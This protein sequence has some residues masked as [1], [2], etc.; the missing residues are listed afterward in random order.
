M[1]VLHGTWIPDR[2]DDFIQRGSFYLWVETSE[3]KKHSAKNR[4]PRHLQGQPLN[5]FIRNELGIS[6]GSYLQNDV[7]ERYF[8]LPSTP[9]SP[10][11]SPELA[12]YL[13]TDITDRIQLHPWS[14]DCVAIE[15]IIKIVND[16]HFLAFYNVRDVQ[17][18]SDLLFWYHYTQFFRQ[19]FLKDQ[20]IPALKYRE[21]ASK[22]SKNKKTKQAKK[23]T[24]FKIY[25]G[26]EVVA[27]QYESRL[28]EFVEMMPTACTCGLETLE[29][30]LALWEKETLLRHFSEC[31]LNDTLMQTTLPMVFT[32]KIEDSLI[33]DCLYLN[34]TK[35]PP[36]ESH[37]LTLETYR[38]WQG[39]RQQVVGDRTH[40]NFDLGFKLIEASNPDTDSWKVEFLA[41]AQDDPSLKLSLDD[42]WYLEAKK[43]TQI[44]QHFG[45]EFEKNILLELGYAARMYPKIWSGLETDK[46]IGLKLTLTE[47]FEFLKESAWVLEDSG[48]K[49]IIPAWWTPEGRRRAKIRLKVSGQSSSSSS[50]QNKGYFSL[51]RIVRYQY[52]L[53]L[54]GEAVSRREWEQ[55]IEA[56]T[57]LVKFRGQWIEIDRQKM[58]EM[59]EFWRSN[60]EGNPEM[61][62]VDLLK[63][64]G[65]SADEIEVEYDDTLGKMMLGLRDRSQLEPIEDPPQLHATLREYQKRGVSWMQYLERL[66]LNG[67]LA[68][69]MGLGKTMQTIARLVL[70]REGEEMPPPTLLVAPTSVL[71]NWRKEV[72]KFAP[73]LRVTIHHGSNRLKDIEA[74]IAAC[75]DCD[76][77]ITS[78]TLARQDAKL[79]GG[80]TWQ[81]IVLDEAQNIKNP[82]AAQTKAILKL[83]SK[84]RLALTGTPVENRLL[85][86]WSIFNFLNPGYLGKQAQFR[87]A[88]ELPIQKEND[89]TKSAILKKLVEPF[90][91][92]RVKTDK[93]I[94]RDLPDKVE[95]KQYCN[96]TKEQAS[97]Y[98]AVI[99]DV[100]EQLE[101]A[102]GIQRKGLI[103]A[104]LTKLKQICNHPAQFL[105]DGSEF[106]PERSHKFSRLQEMLEEVMAEGDSVLIFS[107]FRTI[108][109]ALENWLKR[110]YNTYY[111]HGGTSRQKREKAIAQFQD[112]Q[113]EP[114]I[115]LLSLKAG[116]VGITLTKANHVFHFDRWWNPAVEDQATDRAFRIG[117]D[118]NVFVH[119]F[120]AI[121]TLEERIDRTLEDKKQIAS[122]IVGADESWL[123]ELDNDSFKQLISLDRQAVL[124]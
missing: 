46:P 110:E 32:R 10:L 97:L 57:P 44:R 17:L 39:W 2:S 4:H 112:P 123:T 22:T 66:G 38:Q 105:Q 27:T 111:I 30:S 43:K 47:A 78:F 102:D 53:S 75:G 104:T 63:K 86:L 93:Q 49:V 119:K 96:L 62:I 50:S 24:E 103:L 95:H 52:E 115:F 101:S 1:K 34:T 48:Y 35:L 116:G 88:F 81:R 70:E 72:E 79:L 18:G 120:I 121:G 77:V 59:L 3:R 5:D 100:E 21:L 73:H 51:D 56:K 41:I 90:I 106:S 60:G 40:S 109:D 94:I 83:K 37:H 80:L 68:D 89:R 91:L 9:E 19:I 54:G 92:R 122:S 113:T 74:F 118:K 82:K 58:Q 64:S 61:S 71:G 20:Y 98:E 31:L 124:G 65:E 69:D 26:W 13:E 25:P 12:R 36:F 45:K 84:Y 6:T 7:I 33:A 114:S 76:L 67:C 99:K 28:P 29:S 11:P 107:Q 14:V 85:D 42:Y 8:L 117:Q 87:R 16:L 108:G 55:L 23:Q 15:Q